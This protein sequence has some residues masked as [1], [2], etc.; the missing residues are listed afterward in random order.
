MP[1]GSISSTNVEVLPWGAVVLNLTDRTGGGLAAVPRIVA[2]QG[3]L[4][5]PGAELRSVPGLGP[6]FDDFAAI[7]NDLPPDRYHHGTEPHRFRRHAQVV[8]D[9]DRDVVEVQ[10]NRG[11]YQPVEF[12][13]VFGGIT[14]MFESIEWNGATAV[15]LE[16]L[17]R[18]NAGTIFRLGGSVFIN[19]HLVRIV[20]PANDVGVAVPEGVHRDGYDFISLHMV[21]RDIDGGGET[22][23][24]DVDGRQQGT[25]MMESRLD[26]LYMD[27][28]RFLHDVSPILAREG[29]RCHRDMILMSYVPSPYSG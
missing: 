3:V 7:W 23:I 28:R 11:Y 17:I 15:V 2:E 5:V 12:N 25:L 24:F 27:D 19:I 1:F 4:F 9:V 6:E 16:R 10:S 22:M 21:D 18:L 13:P 14:R 20:N 8:F 29:R 26:T